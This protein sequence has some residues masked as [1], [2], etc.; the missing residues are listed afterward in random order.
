MKSD[1]PFPMNPA[2]PHCVH[3]CIVQ[4]MGFVHSM[5]LLDPALYFKHQFEQLGAR[6]TIAK[7][8]LRRDMPNLVFG[9]H[10]GFDP[11][12]RERFPCVFVNLEQLGEGGS[13]LR[14][15]PEYLALLQDAAVID[16]DASNPRHY[17]RR[18]EDI[19]LVSF[20]FAPYLAPARS[21]PLELSLIH[22]SEPTRPY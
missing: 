17:T 21:L 6:V 14:T 10:L 16:Y 8:R 22:I 4:P 2:L 3:L 12:L 20:G 5:V 13:G 19:P 1:G 15:M 7:N 9:A 18:P 11:A